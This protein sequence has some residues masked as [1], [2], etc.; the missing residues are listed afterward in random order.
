MQD[1][2]KA[3]NSLD[4]ILEDD[5]DK[6]KG[7]TNLNKFLGKEP[8][9]G[10]DYIRKIN[11]Q[12]INRLGRVP[13]ARRPVDEVED[14]T[15]RVSYRTLAK[16]SG[17]K[18]PDKIRPGQK[19]T[20]PGGGSYVVKSG[21]TLSKIAQN[22]RL[23]QVKKKKQPMDTP[24][25]GGNPGG[26]QSGIDSAQPIDSPRD[27]G[28]PGGYT[29]GIADKV[30]PDIRPDYMTPPVDRIN[31]GEF[32]KPNEYDLDKN[33]KY[34]PKTNPEKYLAPAV[35]NDKTNFAT[36]YFNK[37]K[38][39]VSSVYKF[40]DMQKGLDNFIS[41]VKSDPNY[42]KI[43]IDQAKKY[44]GLTKRMNNN[45]SIKTANKS[46]ISQITGT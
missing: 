17:I 10:D 29:K 37:A 39:A 15:E 34:S 42:D 1:L 2:Y 18:N 24:R 31:P 14:V 8:E 46:M 5:K 3:I 45:N 11:P 19:I 23:S 36:K 43:G 12:G 6:M 25:D 7:G 44:G 41:T 26:S 22:Y 33:N 28:N 35:K 30:K 4:K 32:A 9:D 20:L 40:G 16:L 13:F 21:D 27:G 38:D